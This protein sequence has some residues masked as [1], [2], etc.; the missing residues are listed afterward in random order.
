M[1]KNS[2]REANEMQ[3]L[4]YYPG[5]DYGTGRKL[6]C[7]YIAIDQAENTNAVLLSRPFWM[8]GAE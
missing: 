4:E 1:A 5:A 7:T 2:D 8:W 3:A 6:R